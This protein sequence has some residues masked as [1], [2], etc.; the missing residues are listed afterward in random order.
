MPEFSTFREKIVISHELTFATPFLPLQQVV[1]DV[2]GPH[3]MHVSGLAE[4][5]TDDELKTRF[6]TFGQV[7]GVEVIRDETGMSE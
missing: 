4:N 6:K 5:I 1:D 3:R 7:E 2:R